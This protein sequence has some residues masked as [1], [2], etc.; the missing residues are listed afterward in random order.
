[1]EWIALAFGIYLTFTSFKK[2]IKEGGDAYSVMFLFGGIGC[3][4]YSFKLFGII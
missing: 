2:I 1:M 4:F 3:L